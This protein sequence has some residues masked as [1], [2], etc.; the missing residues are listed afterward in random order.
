METIYYL[1][2]LLTHTP[3]GESSIASMLADLADLPV[4]GDDWKAGQ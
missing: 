2:R 4:E 3:M 1:P